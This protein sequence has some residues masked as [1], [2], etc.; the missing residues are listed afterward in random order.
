VDL[1]EKAIVET[2]ANGKRRIGLLNLYPTE[3]QGSWDYTKGLQWAMEIDQTACIGCN[4]CVIACQSENNIAVV[5]K[6]QD[7]RQREM[8]WIRIDDWFGTQPDTH[9]IS[10]GGESSQASAVDDPQVIHQPVPCM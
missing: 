1:H 7:D 5:G 8:H 2:D 10:K 4:A 3:K 9:A 6:E